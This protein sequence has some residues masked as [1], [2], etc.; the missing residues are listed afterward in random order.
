MAA[1]LRN[2]DAIVVLALAL[3][4]AIAVIDALT[5]V[6]LI[7]LVVVGPL[8]AAVRST[9]R[10]TA[11]VSAYALAL[12]LYRASRTGSSARPTTSYAERDRLDRRAGDLGLLRAQPPR[13][14]AGARRAAGAHDARARRLAR[15]G[16]DAAPRR[17]RA[18]P[19]AGRPLRVRPRRPR[20]APGG[21]HRR[22]AGR[23]AARPAGRA[24][25]AGIA[26]VLRDGLGRACRPRT[27]RSGRR[28]R[29]WSPSLSARGR[30]FGVIT[31][32]YR[33]RWASRASRGTTSRSSRELARRCA[34]AV[35]NARLYSERGHIAHTL[36]VEPDA[37]TP[38]RRA[39]LR[40]RRALPCDGGGRPRSAATSSTSSSAQGRLLDRRDRRRVGQGRRRRRPFTALVR[41]TCANAGVSAGR[42]P[43]DVMRDLNAAVLRERYRTASARWRSRACTPATPGG[44]RSAWAATRRR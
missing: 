24:C 17:R 5:P 18:R 21:P 26:E 9:P 41:Y 13:G 40:G 4:T 2:E 10:G 44:R 6:V 39:R 12:A 28:L 7:N 43:S 23:R 35:D 37:R 30:T 16:G 20:D 1:A 19:G 3:D 14:R 31:L 34:L 32:V 27:R 38:A 11:V 8:V 42:R 25:R 36:Q 33:R 22:D 15:R 29:R